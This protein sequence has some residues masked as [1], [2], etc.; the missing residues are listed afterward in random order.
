MKKFQSFNDIEN[1]LKRE[2]IP[3][4]D[5]KAEILKKMEFNNSKRL[6]IKRIA[7][8]YAVLLVLITGVAFAI[9]YIPEHKKFVDAHGGKIMDTL[10]DNNGEV[11]I[12][13]GTI[14]YTNDSI[15]RSIEE[16]KRQKV[17]KEFED[18]SES[19]D[20]QI[21]DDKVALFIPVKGLD[22]FIDLKILNSHDEYYTMEVTKD[23][24]PQDSPLPKYIP[25]GFTFEKADVFYNY[26]NFYKPY[27]KE[28]TFKEYLSKLFDEAK[29]LG[30]DYYFKEYKR[31]D[32]SA[33]YFLDYTGVKKDGDN[34]ESHLYL[35]IK[36]GKWTSLSS[37]Y[38]SSD[39]EI[40]EYNGR[41][42]LKVD[43]FSYYTY[44][45]LDDELW[46]ISINLSRPNILD[47]EELF[48]IIESME[49]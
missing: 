31:L 14:E 32:A 11:I 8:V 43:E 36:K 7:L 34:F 9:G 29:T 39:N 38:V 16:V 27:E 19:L 17:A 35:G 42:Y 45:Y 26:E 30:K 15:E 20:K 40:I 13:L 2:E 5:N 33:N 24:L 48:K 10:T 49:S 46:T 23:I 4:K 37:N 12:Q 6:S 3:Y 41:K 44:I 47:I 22:R 28:M 18:I 21:P 1:Y 25:E